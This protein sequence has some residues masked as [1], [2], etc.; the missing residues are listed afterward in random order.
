MGWMK[1]PD[2]GGSLELGRS[3]FRTDRRVSGCPSNGTCKRGQSSTREK[4]DSCNGGA[5]SRGCMTSTVCGGTVMK[6]LVLLG[7]RYSEMWHYGAEFA[8]VVIPLCK[9]I[10]LLRWH[11][12]LGFPEGFVGSILNFTGVDQRKIFTQVLWFNS[13]IY[14]ALHRTC[15]AILQLMRATKFVD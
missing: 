10:N 2:R 7:R 15:E 5:M 13:W 8:P 6:E 14:H 12:P 1:R 3:P 4:V 11:A 9:Q